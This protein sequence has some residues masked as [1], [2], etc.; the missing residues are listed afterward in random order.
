MNV[1]GWR[2]DEF[3]KATGPMYADDLEVRAAIRFP[4]ATGIAFAAA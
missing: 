3:S 4:N 1:G 2:N